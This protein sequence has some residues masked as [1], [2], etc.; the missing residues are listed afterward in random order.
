[1]EE[2]LDEKP[3]SKVAPELRKARNLSFFFTAFA[4][5]FSGM[6]LD[7]GVTGGIS[8]IAAIAYWSL[9]MFIVFLRGEKPTRLDILFARWGY[10]AIW[11]TAL[12]L[13]AAL[14]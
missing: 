1:M 5:I 4:L 12:C 8:L 9:F 3:V 10:P 13:C 14:R 6:I 2:P 11:V 7:G